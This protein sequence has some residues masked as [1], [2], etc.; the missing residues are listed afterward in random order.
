MQAALERIATG[1]YGTCIRCGSEISLLQGRRA[2]TFGG[3]H[4]A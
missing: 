3:P 1:R 2:D 4:A